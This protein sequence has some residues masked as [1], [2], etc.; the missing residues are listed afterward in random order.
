MTSD[1]K[2]PTDDQQAADTAPVGDPA[3]T[4]ASPQIGRISRARVRPRGTRKELFVWYLM[5][6]TGVALFVLAL[7]HF[8]ILHFIWDPAEQTAEFIA[9]QRWNTI[10]WRAFDW[11]LL[12]TVLFHGFLGMRT[13]ILDYIRRPGLRTGTLWL[14]YVTGVILFIIGTQVILTLPMPGAE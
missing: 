9:N 4:D 7:A 11:L 2:L 8:S 14:L 10:F 5:R 12:M 13:V 1:E 6:V 3:T